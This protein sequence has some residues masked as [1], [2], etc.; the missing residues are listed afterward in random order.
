M[1]SYDDFQLL[2][3]PSQLH[4]MSADIVVQGVSTD[5]RTLRAGDLF[6]A[7]RGETFD[8]HTLIPQAVERGA[9]CIIAEYIPEGTKIGIPYILVPHT[10][11][12]LG[13]LARHYRMRF[14][15]PVVA[16][17]GSAGKTSTKEYTHAVLSE[18]FHTLKTEGNFNN[19]IGVPLT[20]FRLHTEHEC[21][22]IEIGTNEPGEI[23]ILCRI[24]QPTHGVITNI[25]KEHL[26][27]LIDLDG[28]EY[29]ETALF[30]YLQAE[31]GTMI[32]NADDP[33]LAKY[34]TPRS[35]AYTLC[36]TPHSAERS[37]SATMTLHDNGLPCLTTTIDG[38]ATTLQIQ[39]PGMS[40]AYNA[41]AACT[42][43]MA[44]GVHAEEC[45]RGVERYIPQSSHTGYGRLVVE[46]RSEY[47]LLND[48][49]NANPLSMYSA[50]DMLR[51]FPTDGKRVAVLG[52]MRELG[53]TSF[54]EHCELL[55]ILSADTILSH[56]VLLGAEMARAF[57]AV[58]PHGI[59]CCADYAS[60]AEAIRPLLGNSAV[61]LVKGSRGIALENVIA[62][63][64]P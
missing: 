63:M 16:I 56:C 30:R 44:V 50:L 37:L 15:I 3:S 10:L 42:I 45:A 51:T 35:V 64:N 54:A 7:L 38:I 17:A 40:S 23:E 43:G 13:E 20:L 55:Q 22:V 24:V 33:R 19:Q 41:L 48:C 18:R 46:R 47:T 61:V 26:E 8:A 21:A 9:V 52:D 11:Q 62:L 49:Y 31:S 58:Q 5:T 60:V 29:E 34:C 39:A 27:K 25:G 14:R 4:G 1:F 12:A 2:F 6:V 53:A 32:V 57:D 59:T 28:V 36:A